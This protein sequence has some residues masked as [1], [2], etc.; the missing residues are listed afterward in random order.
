MGPNEADRKN[1]NSTTF[2]RKAA[3]RAAAYSPKMLPP[4]ITR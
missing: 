3:E 1:E 2:H 4:A